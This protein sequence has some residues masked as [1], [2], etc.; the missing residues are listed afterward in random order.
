MAWDSSDRRTELPPDW[1]RRRAAVLARDHHRCRWPL[2]YGGE[3][4]ADADEVDHRH[5]PQDHSLGALWALCPV[6]HGRKTQAEARAARR[7][8]TTRRRAPEPH[9]GRIG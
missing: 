7:P 2:T 6:H 9:P 8:Q 5:D 1:R 4:G 3:C